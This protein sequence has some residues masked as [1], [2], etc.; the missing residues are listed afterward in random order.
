LEHEF[1]RL[2]R[3]PLLAL[4]VQENPQMPYTRSYVTLKEQNVTWR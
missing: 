1:V 4:P 2:K 3:S